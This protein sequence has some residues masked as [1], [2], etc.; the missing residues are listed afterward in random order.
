MPI[1][2][3]AVCLSPIV[4]LIA[5]YIITLLPVLSSLF[6]PLIYPVGIRYFP[7]A[8]HSVVTEKNNFTS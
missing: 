5:I 6:N 3:A 8:F 7:V 1:H 2:M 4:K